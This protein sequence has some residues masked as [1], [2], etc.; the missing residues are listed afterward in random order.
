MVQEVE[1]YMPFAPALHREAKRAQ[2][3]SVRWMDAFGL[4]AD[5]AHRRRLVAAQCGMLGGY[6]APEALPER[7][8]IIADFAAWNVAFDDEYC[9]EGELGHSLGEFTPVLG[10]LQRAVEVP[11]TP[12][13]PTDRYRAAL[14]DLRRRLEA[15]GPA[16]QVAR[17]AESM[18]GWLRD[19]GAHERVD[20]RDG[21]LTCGRP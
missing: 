10:M 17:W 15:V 4:Y 19:A 3:A 18:R 21:S 8:D 14:H 16:W 1:L 11:E 9:D 5:D 2:Q 13:F 7:L 6:L 20:L 12:V